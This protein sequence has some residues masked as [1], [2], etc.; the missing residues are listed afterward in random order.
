MVSEEEATGEGGGTG[1]N[2][3]F[4]GKGGGSTFFGAEVPAKAERERERGFPKHC[5]QKTVRKPISNFLG[6]GGGGPNLV[7]MQG[8]LSCCVEYV[9]MGVHCATCSDKNIFLTAHPLRFE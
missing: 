1:G 3:M 6:R 8:D 7:A 9:Q 4:A 5:P 2:R